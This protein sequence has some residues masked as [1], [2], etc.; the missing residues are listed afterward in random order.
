MI[1]SLRNFAKTK[2]AGVFV[3]IIILPFVFWGM[4]GM[5]S[6]GNTNN[7]VKINDKSISTEEF[8][9]YLNSSGIPE[10]TIRDNLDQNI[11]EELL[12]G[13]VSTTLLDLEIKDFEL[14]ISELTL[15]KKIKENKNFRDENGIFQRIKYE[16]FLLENNQSAPQFEMRLKERELQKSLFD[17]IGAGTRSPQFLINKLY[18]EE[19]KKLQLEFI[20]LDKFYKK[21]D[22]FSDTELNN[23]I[24]KNKDQLKVEYMDLNY[25]VINPKNL[26]GINEFNQSF[27]DKIDQ[28]EIDIANGIQFS[29][30]SS[31]LDIPTITKKNFKISTNANEIEKKIFEL[32]NIEL[33]IFENNDDYILYEV[34]NLEERKPDIT[35]IQTKNEVKELIFQKNKYEY[36]RK[37]IE[38]ISKK[39]FNNQDFLKMAE[40]NLETTKLNS[41][42]DNKK[43]EINAVEVLYSL[44][45]NSFTLINDEQENIYL[46]KVKKFENIL[47]DENNEKYKEYINKQNSN[48]KNNMLKSYDFYLNDK[49]EIDLNKKTIERVKN[50][51]Q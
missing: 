46:A 29:T 5:F 24:E 34:Q 23:F 43:F 4:G 17:Y 38:K 33:D 9:D 2:L 48:I 22:A 31:N 8:I 44:P 35:D 15:L 14:S 28:I 18:E 26:I 20:N 25:I 10:K 3:G 51:F 21:K 50:Y 7:V 47:I 32:R 39:E 1:S 11:I 42:K 13:L 27:F 40:K 37:L 30:I 16:K 45:V 49:Y 41:I 12:S 6:S 19:N 36:N